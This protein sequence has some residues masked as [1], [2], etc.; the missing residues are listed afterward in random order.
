MLDIYITKLLP[1]MQPAAS[2]GLDSA[3][4][5]FGRRFCILYF[6]TDCKVGRLDKMTPK[7]PP[8]EASVIP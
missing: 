6:G 1:I 5:P 3:A 2:F 4:S 7:F 8:R